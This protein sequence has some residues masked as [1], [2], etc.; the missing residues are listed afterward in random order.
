MRYFHH[1]PEA[2]DSLEGV[3]RWRLLAD[4]IHQAVEET[5]QALR[6]LVDRGQLVEQRAPGVQTLYRLAPAPPPPA[7]KRRK[8]RGRRGG[9][10]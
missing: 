4:S 8:P 10:A 3:A 6:R 7:P 9:G 1:H 2:A 5:H